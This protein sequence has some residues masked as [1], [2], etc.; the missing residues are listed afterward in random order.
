MYPNIKQTQN[1]E[2]SKKL[3]DYSSLANTDWRGQTLSGLAK[4]RIRQKV[5]QLHEIYVL[6]W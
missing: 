5:Q 3:L 1:T 4:V 2:L 6:V